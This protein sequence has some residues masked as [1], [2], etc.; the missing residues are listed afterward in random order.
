MK[1]FVR[2]FLPEENYSC[3]E[4]EIKITLDDLKK[5][6]DWEHEWMVANDHHL[7]DKQ[8]TRIEQACSVKIPAGLEVF[9]MTRV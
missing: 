3:Y 4:Q 8:I 2:G 9:L 1:H 6:M 7:D 5:L